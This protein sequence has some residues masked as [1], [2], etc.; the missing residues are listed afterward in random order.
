MDRFIYVVVVGWDK[1]KF[2]NGVAALTFAESAKGHQ[3]D[4]EKVSVEIELEQ[5]D[6]QAIG[7]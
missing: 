7:I 2:A 4:D 3:V 5:S 6:E 1:Y